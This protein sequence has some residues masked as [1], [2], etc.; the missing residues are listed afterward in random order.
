MTSFENFKADLI[1][2]MK[3]SSNPERE[4]FNQLVDYD[5]RKMPYTLAF[6]SDI[7]NKWTDIFWENGKGLGRVDEIYFAFFNRYFYNLVITKD[8][9][10]DDN[11]SQDVYYAYFSDL[12]NPKDNDK[13]NCLYLV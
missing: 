13:K 2:W 11:A 12:K 8:S 5:G 6:S 7:D 1:G 4:V 3:D 10:K 9:F